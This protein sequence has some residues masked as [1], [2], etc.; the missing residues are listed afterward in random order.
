MP[1]PIGNFFVK[2]LVSSPL[3]SLLGKSFAVITVTG[4]K[5]GRSISTPIN[6]VTI[7][8]ILTVISVRDRTWWRNLRGGRIAHLRWAGK[9]FQVRGEILENPD[10]IASN[11]KK[12]FAQYPG[13]AK[14]FEIRTG[15]EGRPDPRDLE[16]VASERVI[17]RLFPV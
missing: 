5:T 10:E 7:D 3:H 15:P 4:R 1:S 17:I 11:L 14:Y 2:T 12:Y 8:D 9:R 13:Y 6:T 16:R